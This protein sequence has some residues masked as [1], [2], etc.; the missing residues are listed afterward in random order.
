MVPFIG[1]RDNFQLNRSIVEFLIQFHLV[2]NLHI[3]QD[4]KYKIKYNTLN[5]NNR[6]YVIVICYLMILLE[7]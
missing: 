1:H 6:A 3:Q 2:I 4:I 7:D 5:F